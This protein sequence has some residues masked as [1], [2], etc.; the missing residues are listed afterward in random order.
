MLI[1]QQFN[2]LLNWGFGSALSVVLLAIAV[3]IMV[4]FNRLTS[5]ERLY[6]RTG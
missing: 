2:A 1:A 6:G 3:T 4:V 5:A